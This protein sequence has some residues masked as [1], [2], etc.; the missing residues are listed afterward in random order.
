MESMFVTLSHAEARGGRHGRWEVRGLVGGCLA[1][2]KACTEEPTAGHRRARGG[3]EAQRLV[4]R[5][6]VLPSHAEARGRRHG[7]WEAQ[8]RVGAVA[9]QG[10]TDCWARHTRGGAHPKHV[11]HV[12]DAGRDEAQRLVERRRELPSRTEAREGRHGGLGGARARAV[13]RWRCS[14]H[15]RSEGTDWTPGTA[16]AHPKHAPHVRNAG[17]VE[18]QRLVERVRGLPSGT[19]PCGGRHGGL[20]DGARARGGGGG[21]RSVNGGTDWALGTRHARRGAHPKHV[22]HVRDAGRVEAQRLVERRRFLPSRTE[23]RGGRRG[24]LGG[25]RTRGGGVAVQGKQRARR[26]RLGTGRGTRAGVRT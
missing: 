11:L 3:V 14:Q 4:E 5:Q 23:A 17:R 18:A 26:N 20:G 6:R 16:D 15:A 22:A 2:H 24:R 8:G 19:E 13:L 10:G 1:V 9:V 12:R 25:A 21:A 7:R